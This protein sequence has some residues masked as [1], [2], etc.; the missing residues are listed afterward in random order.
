MFIKL[1]K[2]ATGHE[3]R[4]TRERELCDTGSGAAPKSGGFIGFDFL[5]V[6]QAPP[7]RI[8]RRKAGIIRY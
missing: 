1:P 5:K 3:A 2:N 8:L 7:Y 4:H 6:N